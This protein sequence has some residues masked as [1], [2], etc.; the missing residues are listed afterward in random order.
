MSWQKFTWPNSV[1][2]KKNKFPKMTAKNCNCKFVTFKY[3]KC[4]SREIPTYIVKKD[5][6]CK[7]SIIDNLLKFTH[8]LIIMLI[9][10]CKD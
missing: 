4:I 8:V 10:Y 5:L 3:S 7:A 1:V 2:Y 6:L 9:F